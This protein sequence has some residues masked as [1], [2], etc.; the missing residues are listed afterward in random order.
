MTFLN[1]GAYL[2]QQVKKEEEKKKRVRYKIPTYTKF[3]S[4]IRYDR[5]K[6]RRLL[7]LQLNGWK[8]V[9]PLAQE[10]ILELCYLRDSEGK[11]I[12][13][14]D[15][16]HIFRYRVL[17]RIY[18]EIFDNL[19]CYMRNPELI[20]G[21][22]LHFDERQAEIAGSWALPLYKRVKIHIELLRHLRKGIIPERAVRLVLWRMNRI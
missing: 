1:A 15:E 18:T 17:Q 22:N 11:V 6:F 13:D 20:N 7:N 4:N 12:Y 5:E 8:C 14:S 16:P 3:Y 9:K 19:D 2:M 10:Q 21:L